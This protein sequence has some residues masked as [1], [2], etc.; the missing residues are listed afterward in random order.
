MK[1]FDGS[2][3]HGA[4]GEAVWTSAWQR[5]GW[6]TRECGEGERRGQWN[7]NG[8]RCQKGVMTWRQTDSIVNMELGAAVHYHRTWSRQWP[9]CALTHRQKAHIRDGQSPRDA[10]H[11]LKS[12]FASQ[13]ALLEAGCSS[14][15]LCLWN[16]GR[17]KAVVEARIVPFWCWTI[18]FVQCKNRPTGLGLI[19]NSARS[20][21][22]ILSGNALYL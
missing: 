11:L 15:L 18:S 16:F 22:Q 3:G 1:L 21:T 4:R 8:G 6:G 9:G 12:V 19:N 10:H 2:P 5:D 17:Q 14:R 7:G 13:D 20:V